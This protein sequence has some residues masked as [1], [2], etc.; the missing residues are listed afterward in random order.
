MSASKVD[1]IQAAVV[2][3]AKAAVADYEKRN[4]PNKP[5]RSWVEK[6]I[7]SRVESNALVDALVDDA[8]EAVGV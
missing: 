2:K 8:L 4:K 7:R 3:A 5:P 1:A 6:I